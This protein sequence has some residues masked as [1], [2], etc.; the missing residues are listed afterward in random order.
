MG[1][2]QA[3]LQLISTFLSLGGLGSIIWVAVDW[4]RK[5]ERLSAQAN[6]IAELEKRME[7]I[8]TTVQTEASTLRNLDNKMETLEVAIREL[9]TVMRKVS[10]TVIRMEGR[11]EALD[12][13]K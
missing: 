2:W 13:L 10:E 8:E 12:G 7:K 9:N 5:D 4:A 3:T 1:G 11:Q 6:R